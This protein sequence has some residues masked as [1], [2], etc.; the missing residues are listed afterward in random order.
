[1]EKNKRVF[2]LLLILLVLI[3]TNLFAQSGKML[4][5]VEEDIYNEIDTLYSLQNKRHPSS[6]RPWTLDEMDFYI[7]KL[8]IQ[9]LS[10]A[11]SILY[12]KIIDSRNALDTSYAIGDYTR[13]ST[14]VD[15]TAQTYAHTNDTDDEYSLFSGWAESDLDYRKSFLEFEGSYSYQDSLYWFMSLEY[16]NSKFYNI[17]LGTGDIDDYYTQITNGSSVFGTDDID[18]YVPWYDPYYSSLFSNNIF[19][20]NRDWRAMGPYRNYLSLGNSPLTFTFARTELSFGDSIVG[21]LLLD[22]SQHYF[23]YT[24]LSYYDE[25]FKVSWLNIFFDTSTSHDQIESEEGFK[26]LMLTR[27]EVEILPKLVF[28]FTDSM[29]YAA[30]TLNFAYLNPTYFFHNLN[31]RAIFNSAGLF[32][33]EYQVDEG[34]SIYL[35]LMVDQLDLIGESST[36]PS[37]IGLEIGG[38]KIFELD[39]KLVDLKFEF[40]FTSPQLYTRDYVD[41]KMGTRYYTNGTYTASDGTE[42]NL[43]YVTNL[44]YIGF[45]YGAD[46]IFT[47]IEST[48]Y[49]LE[50]YT[51]TTSYLLLLKGDTEVTDGALTTDDDNTT[52][53]PLEIV[54]MRNI[55]EV[56]GTYDFD[57][58]YPMS[59]YGDLSFVDNYYWTTDTNNFDIELNLTYTVTL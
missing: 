21:N 31:N 22:G 5:D 54:K 45:P 4:V 25:K 32:D 3:C 2:S 17:S 26:I 41:Y 28:T 38:K 23:D 48:Y 20:S 6:S 14:D 37:A 44:S 47:K 13:V 53:F 52:I 11:E 9:N 34:L 8:E 1:M 19:D 56:S 50:N 15:L 46:S 40:G 49:S 7:S 42:E 57:T 24:N 12:Q 55:L 59:V 36:E 39:D 30:D 58:K 35:N 43:Y 27:F 51:F 10:T 29:M 18:I 33:F 16:G